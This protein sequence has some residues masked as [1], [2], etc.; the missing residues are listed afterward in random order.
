[1]CK[2][3]ISQDRVNAIVLYDLKQKMWRWY[4][5]DTFVIRPQRKESLGAFAQHLGAGRL[6]ESIKFM[7]VTDVL[8]QKQE[9][10]SLRTTLL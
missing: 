4:V 3:G 2:T 10:G 5:D 7:T 1:M 8:E 9:D 6:E